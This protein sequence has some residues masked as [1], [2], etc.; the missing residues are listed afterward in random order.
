METGVEPLRRV[1]RGDLLRQHVAH[2]VVEGLGVLLAREVPVLAAPLR[3]APGHPVKDLPGR[4]LPPGDRLAVA[5]EDRPALGV[6]LRHP[7]LAEV[8]LG[9]DVGGHLRPVRGDL[10]VLEP[11]DGGPVRVAD[12]GGAL[13]E[14]D[15]GVGAMPHAR[16]SAGNLHRA[17]PGT[18]ATW[19]GARSFT[20]GGESGRPPWT[21]C[22]HRPA[23]VGTPSGAPRSCVA[24]HSRGCPEAEGKQ[25][26]SPCGFLPAHRQIDLQNRATSLADSA[27][28]GGE[29]RPSRVELAKWAF[30]SAD[31]RPAENQSHFC[32]GSRR[33]R[34]RELAGGVARA[35]E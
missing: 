32:G 34:F 8:L 33:A 24:L 9:E 1:G 19:S 7:G 20:P 16:E 28:T 6:H 29:S 21:R 31:R 25:P 17:P 18:T 12:L 35:P 13:V 30:S 22:E 26:D 4:P 15:T 10:D 5:V 14:C 27:R 3:P 23:I 2:L 11:E